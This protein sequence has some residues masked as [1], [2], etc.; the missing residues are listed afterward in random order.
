MIE[1]VFGTLYAIL[2]A[3][4]FALC[5]Q[6][7]QWQD[8]E[9]RRRQEEQRSL[10]AGGTVE[11]GPQDAFSAEAQVPRVLRVQALLQAGLH[12]QDEEL[13]AGAFGSVRRGIFRDTA[14]AVK[15]LDHKHDCPIPK[16][17]EILH[18]LSKLKHPCIL[19]LHACLLHEDKLLM[20]TELIPGMDLERN[21]EILL[22][23]VSDSNY[24]NELRFFARQI[25]GAVAFLHD[26]NV[27]HFDL[28][29]TNVMVDERRMLKIIDF[30]MAEIVGGPLAMLKESTAHYLAPE[31]MRINRRMEGAPGYGLAADVWSFGVCLYYWYAGSM[32]FANDE[33][34]PFDVYNE[35]LHNF[36]GQP[37]YG[38][39]DGEVAFFIQPLLNRQ[40][41][42]R[43]T[44]QQLAMDPFLQGDFQALSAPSILEPKGSLPGAAGNYQ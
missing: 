9:H 31:I 20:V 7:K 22:N 1:V 30:G 15:L 37:A 18:C 27:G 35:V 14:V 13:G 6:Q 3:D 4:I 17:V 39:F 11:S 5:I 8:E 40:P 41:G 16:E 10:D 12:L 21:L 42:D 2:A 23:E 24:I 34:R 25:V 38:G 19:D 26:H 29:G 28:K 44:F 36:I 32:P 33:D 43:P